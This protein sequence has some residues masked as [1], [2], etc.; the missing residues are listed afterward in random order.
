MVAL[1]MEKK[2]DVNVRT[3]ARLTPL[4]YAVQSENSEMVVLLI[5]KGASVHALANDKETPLHLAAISGNMDIAE[6]PHENRGSVG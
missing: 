2:A 5:E 3:K 6:F 1:L 4:H